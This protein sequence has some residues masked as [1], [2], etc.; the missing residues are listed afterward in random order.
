M[1]A[2][3]SALALAGPTRT[4]GFTLTPMRTLRFSVALTLFGASMHYLTSGRKEANLNKMILGA[5]LAL[6]S[7]FVLC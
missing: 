4:I 2:H 1:A 7:M 3:P 6:A 5:V